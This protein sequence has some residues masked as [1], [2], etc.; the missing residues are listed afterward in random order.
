MTRN[1]TG[2]TG[3]L[4]VLLLAV[5]IT[6]GLGLNSAIFAESE[7]LTKGDAGENWNF[8]SKDY[9]PKPA[10]SDDFITFKV[11]LN[12]ISHVSKIQIFICENDECQMPRE[13]DYVEG[14][15]YSY[16]HT[17][18]FDEGT[19]V[20]Y[21]FQ[22]SY[23]NKT[24]KEYIPSSTSTAD[25]S[26][27]LGNLYFEFSIGENW[28]FKSV[29]I[30]PAEPTSEDEI[31]FT[32]EVKD[33]SEIDNVKIKLVWDKPEF[34]D[35]ESPHQMDNP[36]LN[37]YT[38]TT[39]KTFEKETKIGYQFIIEYNSGTK[40]YIPED[41]TT[42]TV[43]EEQSVL[44]FG[45]TIAGGDDNG[46]NGAIIDGDLDDGDKDDEEDGF[47]PGFEANATIISFILIIIIIIGLSSVFTLENRR[48]KKE[49]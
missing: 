30:E 7:P 6:L 37:K 25:T 15:L 36:S 22:I 20:N 48:R 34:T 38:Y 47:L 8:K 33:N 46:D 44:Y 29:S 9:S 32:L 43:F 42:E 49:K 1:I 10:T 4:R 13:M 18:K 23:D 2:I 21:K 17:E 28:N 12:D 3:M 5:I 11:E 14:T 35:T 19:K 24:E 40:S 16:R 41:S 26:M 39:T 27:V 45:I 31:T